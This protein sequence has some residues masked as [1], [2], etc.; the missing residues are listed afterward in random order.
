MLLQTLWSSLSR[1]L[2]RTTA[3][4]LTLAILTVC[5]SSNWVAAYARSIQTLVENSVATS[6]I[7]YRDE[8]WRNIRTLH[9][10]T[11]I[12]SMSI[13]FDT[14]GYWVCGKNTLL[15]QSRREVY[16]DAKNPIESYRGIEIGAEMI[17]PG[18]TVLAIPAGFQG[19]FSFDPAQAQLFIEA[20]NATCAVEPRAQVPPERITLWTTQDEIAHFSAGSFQRSGY[21]ITIWEE[22]ERVRHY[23]AQIKLSA[24][25]TPWPVTVLDKSQG[26]RRL[27]YEIDCRSQTGALSSIVKYDALGKVIESRSR[28]VQAGDYSPIVPGSISEGSMQIGCMIN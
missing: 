28:V 24:D 27:R 19:H 26:K 15:T 23:D 20:A 3:R 6:R 21:R 18:E 25:W 13:F 5:L 1:R 17:S 7:E 10:I 11:S 9:F 12:P 22:V 8:G 14:P 4:V 16:G 2:R